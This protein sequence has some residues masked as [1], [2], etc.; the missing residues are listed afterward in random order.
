[1]G[2]LDN[3]VAVVTGGSSGM[4]RAIGTRFAREGAAVVLADLNEKG[5]AQVVRECAEAA[6]G[7][8]VFQLTDVTSESDVKNAIARAVA[9]FGRL[10]IMVNTAGVGG[11]LGRLEEIPL[12]EWERTQAVLLLGVFLGMKHSIPHLRRSGGGSIISTASIAGVSGDFGPHPYS[13]A[14]AGVIN[15]TRSAA[16]E[17][18]KDRIR[19]NVI[20]PGGIK[21][22]MFI[23][24][25]GFGHDDAT[26][27][28]TMAKL[29]P[30]PRAG[31]PEDIAAMALFLAGDESEWITGTV[32][33]VDGG[34]LV[35]HRNAI[36][37][38]ATGRGYAGPSFQ[39]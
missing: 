3:K 34:A 29:Q 9:E 36:S 32:M 10:D 16:A 21:T 1:M 17:V 2:R 35:A 15:L 12:E 13:A 5:G 28:A 8:A 37:A 7:K 33:V 38:A 27:E 31:L 11:A 22:P 25:G 4:G 19:V 24:G 20:C 23:G 6:G 18:A 39:R 26:I 14:K 30:I